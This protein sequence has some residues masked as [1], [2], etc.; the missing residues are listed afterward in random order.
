MPLYEF[1]NLKPTVG[2]GTWIAP[3][4]EIIGNV[5]IG[6]NCYIG[7]GAVIRGD[8]GPIIIGNE[9]LIEENVVIHTATCTEIGNRVIVGHMAMIHDAIIKD[10]SLVGMKAMIC[11]G[12]VIGEGSIIAEQTLVI[13]NQQIPP[14]KIYAG[15]PAELKKEVSEHHREMLHLG[16]QAYIEL[17]QLYHQTL[18]PVAL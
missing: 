8:F 4:A 9:S 6:K 16:V 5:T 3:S 15:S 11:E 13:K 18:K 7:F 12:V 2:A 14:G 1:N 10:G 17:I